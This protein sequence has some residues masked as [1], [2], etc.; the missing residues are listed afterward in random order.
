MDAAP[1]RTDGPGS[2]AWQAVPVP[3]APEGDA[4]AGTELCALLGQLRTDSGLTYEQLAKAANMSRGSA[5]NYITKPGHQR[6]TRTLEQ[7][8]GRSAPPMSSGHGRW[9]CTGGPSRLG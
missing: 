8:L 3:P 4:A 7:L 2:G 1:S 5:L 9:S 6:D